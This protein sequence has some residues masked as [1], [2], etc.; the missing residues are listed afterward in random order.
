LLQAV[1]Q[2]PHAAHREAR[3]AHAGQEEEVAVRLALVPGEDVVVAEVVLDLLEDGVDLGPQREVGGAPEAPLD[4]GQ[5]DEVDH[6]DAQAAL[7]LQGRADLG[8]DLPVGG[9]H[10]YEGNCAPTAADLEAAT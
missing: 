5:V 8:L 6:D 7:L 10:G 4:A 1:A 9:D 3:R 2:L